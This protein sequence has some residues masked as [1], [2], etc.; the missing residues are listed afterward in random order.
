MNPLQNAPFVLNLFDSADLF[1]WSY[2]GL[3]VSVACCAAGA[4]NVSVWKHYEDI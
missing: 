2:W 1:S 3:C 4:S